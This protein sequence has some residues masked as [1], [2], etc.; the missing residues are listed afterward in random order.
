[1]KD[2]NVRLIII[3]FTSFMLGAILTSCHKLFTHNYEYGISFEIDG[4]KF[5]EVSTYSATGLCLLDTQPRISKNL[6]K[7]YWQ[8]ASRP[9]GFSSDAAIYSLTPEQFASESV[10]ECCLT[11]L[12]LKFD[13]EKEFCKVHDV[14]IVFP[15]G[16]CLSARCR[17]ADLIN[18]D[19]S[20]YPGETDYRFLCNDFDFHNVSDFDS[21]YFRIENCDVDFNGRGSFEGSFDLT[22]KV[23]LDG[24]QHVVHLQN[25]HFYSRKVE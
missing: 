22:F 14:E 4:A 1:M 15:S 19:V 23:D 3:L 24:V 13:A 17:L 8:V 21:G 16:G 2:S 25:G 20:S 11:Y 18:R 5:E 10:K 6:M 9:S 12:E 7:L